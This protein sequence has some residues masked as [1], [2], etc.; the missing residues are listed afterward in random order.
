MTRFKITMVEIRTELIAKNRLE[1]VTFD[2]CSTNM[3]LTKYCNFEACTSPK[4]VIYKS[5]VIFQK[6]ATNLS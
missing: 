3:I 6:H 1:Y 2:P 4:S 5:A